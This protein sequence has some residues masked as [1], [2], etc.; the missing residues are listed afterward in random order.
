MI[1]H[2]SRSASGCFNNDPPHQHF[3]PI[4]QNSV[5]ASR[6]LPF[7]I[8][9][10][11]GIITVPIGLVSVPGEI[12]HPRNPTLTFTRGLPSLSLT[13]PDILPL[14]QEMNQFP[15]TSSFSSVISTCPVNINNEPTFIIFSPS[16]VL[17]DSCSKIPF[18]RPLMV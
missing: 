15:E 16:A 2:L 10:I 11:Y 14:F 12:G 9:L 7:S 18:S 1:H 17:G 6:N 4:C 13:F 3:L 5:T 8:P